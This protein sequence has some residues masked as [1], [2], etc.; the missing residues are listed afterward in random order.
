MGKTETL[1]EG[2][3][4]SQDDLDNKEELFT[5][6][7]ILSE[8]N[9]TASATVSEV[10]LQNTLSTFALE[11]DVGGFQFFVTGDGA[12]IFDVIQPIDSFES[13]VGEECKIDISEEFESVEFVSSGL[14]MDVV[15]SE[16]VLKYSHAFHEYKN[17]KSIF[18]EL[19]LEKHDGKE[20]TI[21]EVNGAPEENRKVVLQIQK[22][23]FEFSVEL[24]IVKNSEIV[25]EIGS[26]VIRN[27]SEESVF[28]YNHTSLDAAPEKRFEFSPHLKNFYLTPEKEN[29]E[30]GYFSI[31]RFI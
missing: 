3:V 8:G 20:Y 31:R 26:G 17:P 12:S 1:T 19:L 4:S 21:K 24:D 27:L 13:L 16:S 15:E 11:L 9:V 23:V 30:T 2:Y 14:V 28:I 7:S 6:V 18:Q 5:R 25:E 29:T 10:Y 22:G